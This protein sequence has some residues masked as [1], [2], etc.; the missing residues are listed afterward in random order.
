MSE[1]DFLGSLHHSAKRDYLARVL[2]Y[3]KAE[4][5]T[6]AKRFGAE[7]FDGDRRYGYGGYRYDGR[8]LPMARELARHYRL[9]PG[10]RVLDIGCGKGHLLYELTRAVPGV[11]V[12]GVDISAYAI[13][14]SKEEIRPVLA[15]GN[16]TNLPFADRTFDLILSLN[17][18]HYLT[19][20][21]FTKAIAELERVKRG[22]SYIVLESYRTEHEKVNLLH[23][24]MGCECFF[25]PQE[26]DWIF[27]RYGYTGDHS[28]IFFE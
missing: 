26:W 24:Q 6:V 1:I 8:W 20:E 25:T 18:L 19:L 10:S 13:E 11:E 15:Q 27:R 12:F 5:A 21:R 3:D 2:Q 28:L 23:W 16:A 7:Y 4:C 17:V 22:H 9:Q 14:S